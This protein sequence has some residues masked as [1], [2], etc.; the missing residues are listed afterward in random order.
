MDLVSV[1]EHEGVRV[2]VSTLGTLPYQ[3]NALLQH[4]RTLNLKLNRCSRHVFRSYFIGIKVR[5]YLV[6]DDCVAGGPPLYGA[7]LAAVYKSPQLPRK[8]IGQRYF[9]R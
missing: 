1:V 8:F 3:E 5:F 2:R 7:C 6:Y 9:W 4:S